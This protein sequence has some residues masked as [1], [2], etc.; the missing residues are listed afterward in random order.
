MLVECS[1][2][3]AG[4]DL[5]MVFT[6]TLE[7][8]LD[9]C[10]DTPGCLDVSYEPSSGTHNACYMKAMVNGMVWNSKVIGG[11][12]VVPGNSSGVNFTASSH[13]L[14]KRATK[15]GA[16]DY[17]YPSEPTTTVTVG[18]TVY[19]TITPASAAAVTTTSIVT[20]YTTST[21]T[22]AASGVA[23]ITITTATT[24]LVTSVVTAAATTVTLDEVLTS[25]ETV[26]VYQAASTITSTTSVPQTQTAISTVTQT[27]SNSNT[28]TITSIGCFSPTGVSAS[29]GSV[30]QTVTSTTSP[31]TTAASNTT[32]SASSTTATATASS[33][34][35]GLLG[36]NCVLGALL[37]PSASS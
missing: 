15:V 37:A 16:P 31:A 4:G 32:D 25:T 1:S 21:L 7:A 27:Q 26:F 18:T 33:T 35:C 3:R 14:A 13:T 8:C 10:A 2:D 22:P 20:Q 34:D 23:S 30:V 12:L 24:Q 6:S 17:T 36:L 29:Q 9:T 5:S 11:L 28:I 19:Q